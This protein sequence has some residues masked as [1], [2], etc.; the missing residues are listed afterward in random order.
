MSRWFKG[1][2]I[3]FCKEI[4]DVFV[5]PLVYV[6]GGIFIGITGWL[7]FNNL[8]VSQ[9][10][11]VTSITNS[12]FV[13]TISNM[14][15]I[16]I[17][18]VPLLSMGLL[19]E[20]KK[21]GTL[22]LLYKSTLT[23]GQILFAKYCAGLTTALFIISLTLIF[24]IVLAIAGYTDW[25]IVGSS[26]VGLV[27]SVMCYFSV[28]IFSSSLTKNQIIAALTSF[29][30]LMGLTF[31]VFTANVT[32]NYLVGIIFRYISI[33]SH[34]DVFL[35]GT[36]KSYDLIYFISFIA[37]FNFLSLRSLQSRNW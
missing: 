25:P 35:R 10:M 31:L 3:L 28:G 36:I 22:N 15:F 8:L 24:P 6:L 2:F 20:E 9:R 13:P 5:S 19:S 11:T 29:G 26:Y 23:E 32:D 17:L 21:I 37:F 1:S 7:F 27:L 34:F 4:R 12:V 30:I 16:L 33:I 14:N 18:L